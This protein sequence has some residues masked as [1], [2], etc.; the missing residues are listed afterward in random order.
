MNKIITRKTHK[1][2]ATDKVLGRLA[3]EIA[4]L[5]RGKHKVDFLPH[6]DKG[7]IVEVTNVGKMKLTGKK[8]EQ[9]VYYRH[10]GYPGGL[11]EEKIEDLMQKKPE[12]VLHNAVFH[13]LPK[14]KLR[15]AMIKRLRFVK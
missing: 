11:K 4:V 14:N 2:D 15:A 1:L 7:D 13:M 9:K 12:R 6:Q 3:S 8:L 10:S 5:L